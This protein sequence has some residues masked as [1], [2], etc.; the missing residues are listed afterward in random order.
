MPTIVAKYKKLKQRAIDKEYQFASDAVRPK[1]VLKA[2]DMRFSEVVGLFVEELKKVCRDAAYPLLVTPTADICCKQAIA[3]LA[4]GSNP[5]S[6]HLTDRYLNANGSTGAD[7]RFT[8]LVLGHYG[9]LKAYDGTGKTFAP[10]V[11]VVE[12]FEKHNELGLNRVTQHPSKRAKG[13]DMEDARSAAWKLIH[14][15]GSKALSFA[16]FD[17]LTL[18]YALKPTSAPGVDPVAKAVHAYADRAQK[19][20][21][22]GTGVTFPGYETIMQPV[23][24]HLGALYAVKP[25]LQLEK[26]MDTRLGDLGINLYRRLFRA[27]ATL[28]I[29]QEVTRVL[30]NFT[31]LVSSDHTSEELKAAVAFVGQSFRN[32]DFRPKSQGESSYEEARETFKEQTVGELFSALAITHSMVNSVDK[33]GTNPKLAAE[34][35]ITVKDLRSYS[36]D[37]AQQ[38]ESAWERKLCFSVKA[39]YCTVENDL[40]QRIKDWRKC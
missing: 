11:M 39:R 31:N 10:E 15:L 9:E 2:G 8:K 28:P 30:N 12:F 6:E 17:Q 26:A 24:D 35:A 18:M 1:P 34:Q 23:L 29:P 19:A 38:V 5:Y 33:H 14:E 36:I 13:S 32:L 4:F 3:N 25:E 40:H 7:P 21:I 20:R 27:Y 22:N 37:K 16:N